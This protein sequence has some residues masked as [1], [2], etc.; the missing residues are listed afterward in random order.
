P[1]LPTQFGIPIVIVQ[2]IGARS[3]G[4]WFRILENYAISKSKRQRKKR[5]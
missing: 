1:T 5:K 2:H 4:E 3:D